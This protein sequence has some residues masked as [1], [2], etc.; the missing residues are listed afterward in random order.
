MRR[1]L[2][3]A[4]AGLAA[5]VPSLMAL[6]KAQ[7][8]AAERVLRV[9]I[10][11]ANVGQLDPHRAQA[12]QDRTLAGW[13]F[14]G[15]VRFPPG[16]ADPARLE[17]DLAERWDISADG[18]T[19]TFFLRKGVRFHGSWGEMDAE[20]V[21]HSLERA[22]DPKRSSFAGDFRLVDRI[23]VVDPHQIKVVLKAPVPAGLG[24][25]ADYQGG[26]IVSRKADMA[27]GDKFKSH[28]IGTGPF[29]FVEHV[30]QSHV[31]LAAHAGYFRGRPKIDRIQYRFVASDSSRDLAFAAGELDLI[32]GRR[33]QKWIDRTR[34]VPGAKVEIFRPAEYRTLH[35]NT[36]VAPLDD[37]RVREALA[38][39]VN[40][41]RIAAFVGKEIAVAG[42]SV[43]PPGYLG[44]SDEGWTY[45]YDAARAKA[46]LAEAG[47]ASGVKIKAIVS[48]VSSQ[49]PIME[50]VQAQ[51]KQV[52]I[53]LEMEVVDHPTYHAQ[54]R[55]NASALTFYGA[56][57]YPIADS[58]LTEFYHS[59]GR[60]GS[61]TAALNLSHCDAADAEIDEARKI[62]DRAR[63]MALWK[64]AQ[65]KIHAA[66]CSVP[67]F[68]L[69]QIWARNA[70]L[71]F[72]Y[73]LEGAMNLAPPIT[74]K[75]TLE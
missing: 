20:D 6:D 62:A 53:T 8:Q 51:L 70:R 27:P 16:S 74:E 47:H 72:G 18:L 69:M 45:S 31:T 43:V 37:R 66:I 4:L 30:T 2:L 44:Q 38:R 9:G 41:P 60:I 48:N 50:V 71:D 13:M 26:F 28:P 64:T 12:T 67:L 14:N 35:I 65:A 61:P 22:A 32:A 36:K 19:Y 24:L 3:V 23:T 58:Y 40:G 68:D 52:G 56:A 55:K 25:F 59:R 46:L 1:H 54:I 63:Q 11:A 73:K 5:L 34:A 29:A 15:L 7:G 21:R 42:R 10:N 75:S 49:L 33:E 57:R 17:P 39:A